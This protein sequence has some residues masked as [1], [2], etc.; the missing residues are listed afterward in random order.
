M[1]ANINFRIQITSFQAQDQCLIGLNKIEP[2]G[3][4]RDTQRLR[5]PGA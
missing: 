4:N 3:L 1:T 5:W 2:K